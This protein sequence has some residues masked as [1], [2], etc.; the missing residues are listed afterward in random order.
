VDIR[1]VPPDK[2][3]GKCAWCGKHIPDYTSVYGLSGMGREGLDLSEYEGRAIEIMIV[4]RDKRVTMMVTSADSEAK[5]DGKD[6]MFMACSEDCA[7]EMQ[8]ALEEDIFLG[9]M[10]EG[11]RDF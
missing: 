4:A 1:I 3:I 2:V 5:R 11:I 9:D 8:E 7:R 10:L 6:F